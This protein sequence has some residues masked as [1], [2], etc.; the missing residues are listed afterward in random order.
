MSIYKRGETWW[1]QITTANGERIQRTDGT[2][3]KQEAQELHDKLK[4]EAWR[5]KNL[6]CKPRHTWQE[7]VIRWIGEHS[8]KK[9]LK[10]DKGH[11]RW[12]NAHLNN[13][14]IDEINKA[15]IDEIKKAKL[16]TG[17]SNATVNR[18]LALMRSLLKCAKDEWEWLDTIPSVK[19]LPEA[20][21]RLRWLKHEEAERLLGELPVHLN[22][23]ARFTLATGLRESNVCGLQWSQ[24]DMQRHCAW[25]HAD[26]A[27]AEKAIAVPLGADALEVIREQFG[28]HDSFVFTYEGEPVTRANNH[29]WRKALVRA[30]IEDFRWHDLRHTWASWHVQNGTPIQFLKELGGWSDLKM[31]MRYA[32][33]SS[34]HLKEYA[35]NAGIK[36]GGR[37]AVLKKKTDAPQ[38]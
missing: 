18:V 10:D 12:L 14:H 5:V 23:M 22:A 16:A 34:D 13:K 9:S 33:L 6:G 19:L 31:V 24:L 4:A 21:T 27:K 20:T 11:F 8:H 36:K 26:Q 30:G 17:A 1:I 32:H 38:N 35:E 28:K 7:A 2:Q 3:I 37:V 15:L 29:A 25:I